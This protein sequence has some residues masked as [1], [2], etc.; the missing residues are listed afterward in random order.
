MKALPRVLQKIEK[1]QK[2]G[3]ELYKDVYNSLDFSEL[4]SLVV[5]VGGNAASEGD[6]L[7]DAVSRLIDDE[8]ISV[9]L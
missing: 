9:A 8:A 5:F 7:V 1:L 6:I 2:A 3:K 4:E